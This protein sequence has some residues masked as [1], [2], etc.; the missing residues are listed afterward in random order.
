[1]REYKSITHDEASYYTYSYVS[2]L[3]VWYMW[4]CQDEQNTNRNIT[5]ITKHNNSLYN[6]TVSYI[7]SIVDSNHNKRIFHIIKD[8]MNSLGGI[9]SFEESKYNYI[10]DAF[11]T[12]PDNSMLSTDGSFVIL[13]APHKQPDGSIVMESF[14]TLSSIYGAGSGI[15]GAFDTFRTLKEIKEITDPIKKAEKIKDFMTPDVGPL[16][17]ADFAFSAM[18]LA[19]T[20]YNAYNA[21]DKFITRAAGEHTVAV[22]LN[23]GISAAGIAFPPAGVVGITW[24][25]TYYGMVGG[26]SVLGIEKG[27]YL[28]YASDPGEAIVFSFIVFTGVTM[29]S[30]FASDAFEDAEN[31]ILTHYM[32]ASQFI[33]AK[34]YYDEECGWYVI[35]P[36]YPQFYMDP[37]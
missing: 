16:E 36:Y 14:S 32:N 1:M 34:V 8:Q 33:N 29:P 10:K 26:M 6:Y 20:W 31:E 30:Q 12:K 23:V 37:R 3:G 7:N 22:V 2:D 24:T 21:N 11:E 28:E 4:I 19:L 18:D 13:L 27:P 9:E 15:Y 35:E 17:V 5:A 25:A